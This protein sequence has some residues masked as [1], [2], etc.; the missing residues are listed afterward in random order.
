MKLQ[1]TLQNYNTA[2][3]RQTTRR[4]LAHAEF[5]IKEINYSILKSN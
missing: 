4:N 2:T 1:I 5:F 3:N